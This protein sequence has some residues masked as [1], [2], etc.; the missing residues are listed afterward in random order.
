MKDLRVFHDVARALTSTLDRDSVL[1]AIVAQMAHFFSPQSWSLLLV[2]DEKRE[3]HFAVVEGRF[4]ED[5]QSARICAGEGMA[6]WVLEHGEPL[7]VPRMKAELSGKAAAAVRF[8][9]TERRAISFDVESAISLPLRSRGRTLGVIQLFNYRVESL[10]DYAISFLHI[11]TD[12]A[13]IAI[14]NA[15]AVAL[16]QELTITDD[17]TQLFN[18]RHLHAALRSEFERAR[19]FATE[20]SLIF[21]D[22]DFFKRVN[23]EHGHLVGTE[24]LVEVANLLKHCM[25]SVD[26]IFRYG[27]DEFVVLLPQ[28]G[29]AAAVEAAERLRHAMRETRFLRQRGFN[30]SVSASFGV[31]TYPEDGDTAESVLNAADSRMYAV[32]HT[33]R[34]G[35]ASS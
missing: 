18:T 4:S 1:R 9:E 2:D 11:L 27:G 3:L 17:T 10:N 33:T 13:A 30:L 35:I 7:I 31:S 8:S 21:I 5:H 20:F 15:R 6:G 12:Y 26:A 24:L 32:K 28:T 23:D 25:R 19:R 22:L 34:D 14:E 16:I 29:K